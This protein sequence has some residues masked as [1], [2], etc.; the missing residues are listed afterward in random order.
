M[1][2]IK[3]EGGFL[4]GSLLVCVVLVATVSHEETW[5]L[6]C[7]LLG[8]NWASLIQVSLVGAWH[9]HGWR[10]EPCQG[11]GCGLFCGPKRSRFLI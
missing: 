2:E 11:H 4:D 6:Q 5:A 9:G 7:V 1:E 10:A 8:R 3:F